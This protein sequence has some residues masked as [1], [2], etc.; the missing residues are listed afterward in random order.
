MLDWLLNGTWLR[1]G[2]RCSQCAWRKWWEYNQDENT[3]SRQLRAPKKYKLARLQ[4]APNSCSGIARV[5]VS[6]HRGTALGQAAVNRCQPKWA[7]D[8]EE[9]EKCGWA[10]PLIYAWVV[11]HHR[12]LHLN[13]CFRYLIKDED[14]ALLVGGGLFLIF[15]LLSRVHRLLTGTCSTSPS[16][17]NTISLEAS[18]WQCTLFCVYGNFLGCIIEYTMPPGGLW[19]S[20][21]YMHTHPHTNTVQMLH[22]SCGL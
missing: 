1:S 12:Y 4:D 20:P 3:S 6:A 21:M 7:R 5:H 19:H 9:R 11:L 18:Q 15:L 10:N 8:L 22:L 2:H 17:V 13:W 14:W 16:P